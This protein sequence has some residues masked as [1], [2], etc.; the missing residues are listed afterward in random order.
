[1]RLRLDEIR[2]DNV[3]LLDTSTQAAPATLSVAPIFLNGAIGTR[4]PSPDRWA[5]AIANDDECKLMLDMVRNPAN[6]V[7][8]NI[9]KVHFIYRNSLRNG[10]IIEENG[11]LFLKEVFL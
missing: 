9:D 1:M 11:C 4:L 6:C 8:E 5:K 3:E 7:K 10:L 2:A